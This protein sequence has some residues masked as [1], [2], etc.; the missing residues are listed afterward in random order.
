MD[1]LA[2]LRGVPSGPAR[3]VDPAQARVLAELRATDRKVR[4]HEAAHLAAAGGLARGGAAFAT[5]QGPDGRAYAVA[6]EVSIDTSPVPGRPAATLAK[7]QQIVSAALAP[8]DPSPQ[9]RQ[10]AAA[11]EAMAA[12]ARQDLQ[13]ATRPT[14]G[15]WVDLFA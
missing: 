2:P 4:A 12:Q 9:D 3:A 7:A 6:G 8:A 11:A 5:V 1:G 13:A 14:P 15:R 10:V